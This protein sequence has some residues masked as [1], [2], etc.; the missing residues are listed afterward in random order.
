MGHQLADATRQAAQSPALTAL[1]RQRLRDEEE[2]HHRHEQAEAHEE[3]EDHAP[4][5]YRQHRPTGYRGDHG[6]QRAQCHEH[7]HDR[8]QLTAVGQVHQHR[9]TYDRGRAAAQPLQQPSCHEHADVGSQG[10]HDRA[11]GAHQATHHH[12]KPASALVRDRAAG[13]LS[14][15]HADEEDRQRQPHAARARGQVSGHLW[16]GRAV[17]VRGEGRDR[18]LD[19]QGK[20]QAKGDRRP[21]GR[22][23]VGGRCH[24]AIVPAAARPSRVPHATRLSARRWAPP[25]VVS[26]PRPVGASARPAGPWPAPGRPPDR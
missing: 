12:G 3:P 15:R 20:D 14:Q 18:V 13:H 5:T 8:G 17:H 6:S 19:S 16:E 26:R 7:G 10:A 11:A 25:H 1:G 24:L 22:G 21:G 9:A 4:G 23:L 2:G